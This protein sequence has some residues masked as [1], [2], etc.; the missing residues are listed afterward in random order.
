MRAEQSS[1]ILQTLTC[2]RYRYRHPTLKT[3]VFGLSFQSSVG[4]AAGFDKDGEVS[5]A[6]TDLGFGTTEVG[7]VTP[8]P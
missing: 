7:T 1:T 8:S 6:I 3:E 2:S 5:N 4:T